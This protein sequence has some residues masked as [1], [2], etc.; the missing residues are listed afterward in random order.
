M[1]Q[2]QDQIE[3]VVRSFLDKKIDDRIENAVNDRIEKRLSDI[4]WLVGNVAVIF[5][6]L[7]IGSYINLNSEKSSLDT[8]KKDLKQELTGKSG[9]A[10]ITLLN[11]NQSDLKGSKVHVA[12]I[13]LLSDSSGRMKKYRLFFP[14]QYRN[15]GTGIPKKVFVKIWIGGLET[16][17]DDYYEVIDEEDKS[18]TVSI[19]VSY[20]QESTMVN[21]PPTTNN[22]ENYYIDLDRMPPKK[23]YNAK[24]KLFIGEE[25]IKSSEANFKIVFD[26]KTKFFD[27]S[28][29]TE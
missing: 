26:E 23:V 2:Q 21:F 12:A 19:K 13:Q 28:Q 22:T 27:L 4:K 29:P 7:I 9:E 10:K 17:I 25:Q 11:T 5:T 16:Y 3:E 1:S 15:D 6:A 24:I 20:N 18:L 14:V 8:F